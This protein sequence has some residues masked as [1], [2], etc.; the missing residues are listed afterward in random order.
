MHKIER[1]LSVGCCDFVVIKDKRR[2]VRL[3]MRSAVRETRGGG[4][5]SV[6]RAPAENFLCSISRASFC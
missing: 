2:I 5:A 6:A 4:E 3:A 1:R